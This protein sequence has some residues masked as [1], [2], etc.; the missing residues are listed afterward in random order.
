[1]SALSFSGADGPEPATVMGVKKVEEN[2][3]LTLTCSAPSVP[4][5]SFTWKFNGTATPEKT[6]QYTIK[7]SALIN[8]GMYTC[9]AYNPVTG[10][11]TSYTHTVEVKGNVCSLGPRLEFYR[12][13]A[14]SAA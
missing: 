3:A 2:H 13:T 8:S 4:P 7:Q 10:K 11:T 5:A 6:D 12:L 1:M 9:E 14:V